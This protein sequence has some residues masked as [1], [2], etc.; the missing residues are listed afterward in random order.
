MPTGFFVGLANLL[1]KIGLQ[2]TTP[3]KYAFLE[4]LSCVVVPLLFFLFIRRKPG[5][6]TVT[7]SVLCLVGC[8]VLSG[9]SLSGGG[10]SFGAGDVLCAL[11]GILYGVNIAATGV[12]AKKLNAMYYVM[13]QMLVNV[14]VSG[15]VVFALDQITVNGALYFGKF[16]TRSDCRP[17][18]SK[19]RS[20]IF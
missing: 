13:I 15:V 9:L 20:Y 17:C 5:A 14:F 4:N 12:Y 11:A 18:R 10:V 19:D 6:L 1:Q 3:T 7:A 2:Y 8:F 16:R